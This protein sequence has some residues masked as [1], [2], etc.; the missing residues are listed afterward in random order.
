VC[1]ESLSLFLLIVLWCFRSISRYYR[2][3]SLRW[4]I[5]IVWNNIKKCKR[6][7]QGHKIHGRRC[8]RWRNSCTRTNM[9]WSYEPEWVAMIIVKFLSWLCFG[10]GYLIIVWCLLLV[11]GLVVWT[12]W[13]LVAMRCHLIMLIWFNLFQIHSS[14][15]TIRNS[16]ALQ[17]RS[18]RI[19]VNDWHR[20]LT[21]ELVCTPP[22][23]R[24][25]P[26]LWIAMPSLIY[27]QLP[28]CTKLKGWSCTVRQWCGTWQARKLWIHFYDG[29]I[30][31]TAHNCRTSACLS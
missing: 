20:A 8:T 26:S 25:C 6:V 5:Q 12:L 31:L 19:A 23:E 10:V 18:L 21:D 14:I 9:R 1:T 11:G 7:P 27:S 22:S 13:R 16:Y 28:T 3:L 29:Q 2:V 4:D 30:R 15:L 24:M 17:W